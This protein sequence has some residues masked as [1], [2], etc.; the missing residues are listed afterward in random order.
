MRHLTIW[1][2]AF[3]IAVI[4]L[5]ASPFPIL[6][7]QRGALAHW[8][9]AEGFATAGALVYVGVAH[10]GDPTAKNNLGVLRYSG[11]GGPS[12]L[13][14]AQRLFAEASA[15]GSFQAVT[16]LAVVDGGGCGLDHARSA[17]TVRQLGSAVAE[18][19]A[20]AAKQ[21][22]DCLYFDAAKSRLHS[23]Q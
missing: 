21:T 15:L 8:L 23:S 17:A 11:V 14:A 16:N 6:Q 2:L 18:G 7:K 19:N 9:I 12:D 20:A 5:I 10:S 22:M 4:A 13:K 1:A 3:A